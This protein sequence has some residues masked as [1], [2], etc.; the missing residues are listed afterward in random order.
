MQVLQDAVNRITLCNNNLLKLKMMKTTR[1]FLTFF[2]SAGLLGTL[3]AQDDDRKRDKRKSRYGTH[4]DF[5]IDL[6]INDYLENGS[7]PANSNAPYEVRPWGSWYIALKSVQET[8]ISGVLHLNWGADISWYNFKF[9]DES[10]RL[11]ES[12]EGIAFDPSNEALD[13]RKSKLTASYVNASVVPMLRFGDQRRRHRRWRDW[14]FNGKS[15]GFSI[16]AGMYA[17][18]RILSY[19]KYVTKENG[20]RK[21]DKDRDGFF[22]NNF[23]YGV[24][25]QIGFRGLEVFFNYDLNEL[26]ADDRGPE[27]NAFSFGVVL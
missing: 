25:G 7:S 13:F 9:Q 27:L 26:F 8:Q 16:G 23:R 4:S 1:L 22:L 18:Y 24:R 11:I 10:L 6:G 21:R 5:Q 14:E 15:R 17:G 12:P 20:D 3:Y 19:A 2:L